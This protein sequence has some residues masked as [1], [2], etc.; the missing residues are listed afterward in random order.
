MNP[1]VVKT[2]SQIEAQKEDF[3]VEVVVEDDAR[4]LSAAEKM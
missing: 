3:E 2:F 4:K 1:E